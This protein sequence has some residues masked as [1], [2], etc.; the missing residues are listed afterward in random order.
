MANNNLIIKMALEAHQAKL[1]FKAKQEMEKARQ[2]AEETKRCTQIT[3]DFF[4]D[5]FGIIPDEV[6]GYVVHFREQRVTLYFHS[7][8]KN[9]LFTKHCANAEMVGISD[10]LNEYNTH[11][12]IFCCWIGSSLEQLGECFARSEN[13]GTY[14]ASCEAETTP[15][16][17]EI[18]IH[19][20]T[21]EEL[22][23]RVL[24]EVIRENSFEGGF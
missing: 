18:G 14:C 2:E 3:S 10:P 6:K 7:G 9:W 16:A 19:R 11:N 8:N 23:M 12:N 1:D 13:N 5:K 15:G 24:K 20:E 17:L 4:A 21:T 22:F